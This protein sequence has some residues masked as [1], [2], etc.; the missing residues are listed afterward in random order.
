MSARLH[1]E[2]CTAGNLQRLWGPPVPRRV[3]RLVPRLDKPSN[4]EQAL[5][6]AFQVYSRDQHNFQCILAFRHYTASLTV[7]RLEAAARAWR[8]GETEYRWV[9]DGR[10]TVPTD[11][12][13]VEKAPPLPLTSV[14]EVRDYIRGLLVVRY[15]AKP[16]YAE[17]V[18]TRWTVKRSR[19]LR[20]L[21]DKE[22][23]QQF[24]T[25]IGPHLYQTIQEEKQVESLAEAEQQIEAWQKTIR[26]RL[27]Q[28][29]RYLYNLFMLNAF[30]KTNIILQTP[31]AFHLLLLQ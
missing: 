15:N 18:A 13:D 3:W 22:F 28:S 9:F 29:M 2:G 5:V 19:D 17:D 11:L 12:R 24:G 1:C 23:I 26:P 16:A 30:S 7:K 25:Q 14:N 8:L 4:L 20:K 31:R 21:S 6:L 27:Y 10:M